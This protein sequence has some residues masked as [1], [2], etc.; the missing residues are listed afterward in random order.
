M[1]Y[2]KKIFNSEDLSSIKVDVIS[3]N[4]S[5]KTLPLFICLDYRYPQCLK[6]ALYITSILSN[7]FVLSKYTYSSIKQPK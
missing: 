4:L 3:D 6:I 1:W 5:F 2:K 7:L